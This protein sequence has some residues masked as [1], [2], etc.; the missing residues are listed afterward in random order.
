M[1]CDECEGLKKVIGATNAMFFNENL[2]EEFCK[3]KGISWEVK[4]VNIL[5]VDFFV[6]FN[7]RELL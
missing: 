4:R 3:K 5:G 7:E 6:V 1:V 2:A